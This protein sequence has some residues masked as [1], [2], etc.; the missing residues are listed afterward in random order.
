MAAALTDLL[1]AVGGSV[2]APL[3]AYIAF[4]ARKIDRELEKIEEHDRTLYGDST[5]GW[6][7]LVSVV[8]DDRLRPDGGREQNDHD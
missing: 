8:D 5:T 6:P 7:G 4:I 1:V 2:A 3:L